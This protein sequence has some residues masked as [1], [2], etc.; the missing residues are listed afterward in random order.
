MVTLAAMADLLVY[1]TQGWRWSLVLKP[2]GRPSFLRSIQAIYIGLFANEVLPL[3]TGEVIRCYLQARW[4][5]IPF[6]V[7]LSS[8]VVERLFDGIWLALGFL[9]VSRFGPD[10]PNYLLHGEKVLAGALA[11]TAV[12]LAIVIFWKHH[13]HRA[14]LRSRWSRVLWH[15]VEALHAMGRSRWFYA[16]FG[17]SLAYFALQIVPIYALMKGYGLDLSWGVAAVL[18]VVL[19][20]GTILPQAPGNVGSFQFF[21]VLALQL[22]GVDKSTAIGFSTILFVVTTVP[23]WLGGLVAVLFAGTNIMHLQ[24]AA[25]ETMNSTASRR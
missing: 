7:I 23:L 16:A 3:R 10:L 14:V 20:I 25:H 12:L 8:A 17:V 1:V 15:V 9:F 2:V 4:S 6:S 24:R 13:A 11:F 18:L 5:R 21:T 22:F 19:R